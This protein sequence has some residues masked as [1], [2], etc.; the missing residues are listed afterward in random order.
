MSL[1]IA[2]QVVFEVV[3]GEA[4]L[5]NLES[6]TYYQLTDVGSRIWQLLEQGETSEDGLRERLLG[7]YDVSGDQLQ[8]DLEALLGDLLAAGLLTR[9]D[10]RPS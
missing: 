1:A 7:E 4:V 6:G 8:A 5:L 3:G 2:P 9:S 10:A